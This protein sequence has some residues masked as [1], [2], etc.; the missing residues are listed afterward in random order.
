MVTFAV[1]A[2]RTFTVALYDGKKWLREEHTTRTA[3]EAARRFL[4]A[5]FPNA[6]LFPLRWEQ[7]EHGASTWSAGTSEHGARVWIREM[8]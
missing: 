8:L 7:P 4:R 2:H 5:N 1:P 6:E 3:H